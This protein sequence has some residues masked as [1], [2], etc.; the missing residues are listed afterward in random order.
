MN[1]G[2]LIGGVVCLAVAALLAVLMVTLPE[3]KVVFM[4]G[5]RNLPIV[6]ASILGVLGLWLVVTAVRR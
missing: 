2:Q 4:I 6:P 1:K 3:G 5:G